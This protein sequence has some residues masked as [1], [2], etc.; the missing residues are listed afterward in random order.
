MASES[1][2]LFA[3]E[4]LRRV[5]DDTRIYASFSLMRHGY[6]SWSGICSDLNE[7][8]VAYRLAA[9]ALDHICEPDQ[10]GLVHVKRY[11]VLWLLVIVA[12][13]GI[14]R[15]SALVKC[16]RR[17]RGAEAHLSLKTTYTDCDIA[18]ELFGVVSYQFGDLVPVSA[19]LEGGGRGTAL[20]NVDTPGGCFKVAE[21]AV[22]PTSVDSGGRVAGEEESR[23]LGHG[24][25]G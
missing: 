8:G 9:E 6:H 17:C 23:R 19:C 14:R 11:V 20:S 25:R 10:V 12:E 18:I 16:A 22:A 15:T 5:S 4:N 1:E 7:G 2:A 13:L 21:E 3:L 24:R